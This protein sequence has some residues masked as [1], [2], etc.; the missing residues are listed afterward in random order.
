MIERMEAI[1]IAVRD[2]G[3]KIVRR[4]PIQMFRDPPASGTRWT[5]IKDD[6]TAQWEMTDTAVKRVA[7][8]IV[9]RIIVA[10]LESHA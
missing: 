10:K 5:V 1:E 3:W 6:V 4:E 7:P 8:D 9:T 2:A